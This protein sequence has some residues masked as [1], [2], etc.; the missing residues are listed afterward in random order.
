LPLALATS[1]ALIMRV[2]DNETFV[3]LAQ[4]I[5]ETDADARAF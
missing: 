2:F 4:L 3:R 5:V 1:V